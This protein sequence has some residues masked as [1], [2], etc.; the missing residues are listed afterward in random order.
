MCADPSATTAAASTRPGAR[1]AGLLLSEIVVVP[2]GMPRWPARELWAV[3]APAGLTALFGVGIQLHL[4]IAAAIYRDGERQVKL[5]N[6]LAVAAPPGQWSMSPDSHSACK[7]VSL[8][9][10]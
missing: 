5:A 10:T 9:K 1:E 3:L 2:Q 6:A 4:R 7:F 8:P